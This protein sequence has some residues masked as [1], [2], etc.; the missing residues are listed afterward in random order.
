MNCLYNVSTM[1][2]LII[3]IAFIASL[4]SS[5]FYFYAQ[6]KQARFVKYARIS[7]H[8]SAVSVILS[9]AYLLYLL[10][11]H[12]F[13]YTYVWSYSSK[14]LPFNLLLSTFYAGQEG[15]FHLWAF[16]MA[17]LGIFLLPFLMRKDRESQ[18]SPP[19]F[20]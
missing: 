3:Y 8:V 15:S 9:S 10:I 4:L 2:Q 19:Q 5:A 17:V 11:S 12:Q 14:D 13:Q 7:F 1:G 20:T 16:L 6:Y 18:D